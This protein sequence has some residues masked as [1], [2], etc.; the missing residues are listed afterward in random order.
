MKA[1]TYQAALLCED[2]GRAMQEHLLASMDKPANLDDGDHFPQ[3]PFPDGGG[4]ADCP[5]HCDYCGTFLENPLTREGEL[6]VREA[7]VRAAIIP[8]A[9]AYVQEWREHYNH[10]FS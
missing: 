4:E 1:Y 2:C 3:G 8:G 10:L 7:I 9:G 6:Y 5:Q